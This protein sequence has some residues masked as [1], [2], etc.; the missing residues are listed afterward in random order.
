MRE[1]VVQALMLVRCLSTAAEQTENFHLLQSILLGR[2]NDLS[3]PSSCS[4]QHCCIFITA[5]KDSAA[6]YYQSA[7]S[8]FV[9]TVYSAIVQ[10][11][12]AVSHSCTNYFSIFQ[13]I[14]SLVLMYKM[15]NSEKT[16]FTTLHFKC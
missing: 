1:T 7:E 6:L 10:V 9:R 13:M 5:G 16:M 4:N 8:V 3:W 15:L 11:I 12:M 2:V 14:V